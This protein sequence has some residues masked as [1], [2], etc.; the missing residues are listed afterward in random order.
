MYVHKNKSPHGD[1]D[2]VGEAINL[3]HNI[4]VE[5]VILNE[6]N[7]NEQEEKIVEMLRK[8][9]ISYEIVTKDSCYHIGNFKLISLNSS[10]DNENDSSIVFLMKIKDYQ[11]L[12]M[13]DSST[14]VEEKI[15]Q[16]YQL[17]QI[18]FLKVGHHGSKTST[19]SKFLSKIKPKVA[20]IS[21]G[22]NNHYHHPN[23]ETIEKLE[24]FQI[25]I[26]L[27]SMHGSI[28]LNFNKNVTFLINP[29]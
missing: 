22:L 16:E 2:H 25:P 3:I 12:L 23:K 13:G 15:I 19:S 27:T 20:L 26:F 8:K 28:Q 10:W 9:R 4:K 21:V 5:K 24:K 1:F 29:P 11:F 18:D 6:G 7:F 17:G 14:K